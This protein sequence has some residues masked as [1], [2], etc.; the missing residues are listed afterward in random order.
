M[1][2]KRARC[3]Q[4]SGLMADY[5]LTHPLYF[6]KYIQERVGSQNDFKYLLILILLRWIKGHLSR[7][8]IAST[9]DTTDR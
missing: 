8:L 5:E 6:K 3:C 1:T 7:C 2:V 9:G 4:R